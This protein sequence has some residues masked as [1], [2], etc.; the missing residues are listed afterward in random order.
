MIKQLIDL[1][2]VSDW[3]GISHN[4]DIAKGMYKAP[5]DWDAVKRQVKR[6]KESKAYSNG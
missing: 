1:L 3:Y 5:K 6:V 4:I 2:Q